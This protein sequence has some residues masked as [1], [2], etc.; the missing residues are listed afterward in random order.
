MSTSLIY[1][2]FGAKGYN[3]LK[4]EY[5]EGTIRFHIEREPAKRCCR[6][7]GSR[8]VIKKD[9]FIR[10][11][12]TVP[13]GIKPTY[14]VVEVYRLSCRS[15]GAVK[16]EPIPLVLFRR[17]W[18]KALGRYVIELMKYA[19]IEDVARHLR[20]S[21][22]TI[23][24]IH[25][26]ALKRK[27][28]KKRISQVEY[29]G[30]DEVSVRKGHRYLT[31]VVNLE[32]GEVVWAARNR[33]AASLDRFLKRLKR[34]RAPVKAIAMD[35][36]PPYIRAVLDN[37]SYEKIVFDRYHIISDYN[38]MLDEL[39][40]SEA[41]AAAVSEKNVFTGVR[42]LLLKG[43]ETIQDDVQARQRLHRLLAINHALNI[44]YIL[45]EELRELWNC[46]S[47]SE[48]ER[49][50]TDWL[51][52]AWTSGV[53]LVIKYAKKLAGHRVGILNYFDHPITT[54]MVE[55]INNKIKVLKRRAYGYRDMDYFLLRIYFIHEAK[56][57][58]TG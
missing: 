7:C 12:K 57:T 52:K 35:M 9:R 5:R 40:K 18:T 32:T 30:V 29:L 19:T 10:E 16:M 53:L 49:Y 6:E 41:R 54:G 11:Y 3:Y 34:A 33:T 25:V 14:L 20:M 17:R 21:W 15:C 31:I 47:R 37:Y 42:Y 55:G 58:L 28:K 44:A 43:Q 27:F 13:I 39:R 38:R 45:K 48:A 24:E 56:Y 2:G 4:T 36:W 22:D 50:L 1:H 51:K 26:W 46:T 8:E 23:K